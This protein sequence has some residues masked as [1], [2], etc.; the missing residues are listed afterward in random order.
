MAKKSAG[1][2]GDK[3]EMRRICKELGRDKLYYNTKGEYFTELS[4][5]YASEGGNKEKVGTFVS[6][7][8]KASEVVVEESGKEGEDE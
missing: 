8:T 1:K 3:E 6:T 5:A 2:A 7:A 4:Y